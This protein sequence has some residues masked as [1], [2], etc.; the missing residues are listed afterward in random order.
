M[1]NEDVCTFCEEPINKGDKKIRD[2]AVFGG[3]FHF[4]CYLELAGLRPWAMIDYCEE[5]HFSEELAYYPLLNK[6]LCD[7]CAKSLPRTSPS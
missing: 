7:K 6:V 4:D 2:Y 1:I 5:C 3:V